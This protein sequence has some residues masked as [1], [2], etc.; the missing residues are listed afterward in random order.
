MNIQRMNRIAVRSLGAC[1]MLVVALATQAGPDPLQ[2]YAAQLVSAQEVPS[3]SSVARGSFRATVDEAGQTIE[4]ELTF[5]DLEAAVSQAHIHTAQHGVNGGIMLWLCGTPALPGPVGTPA[6]PAS[7]TITGTLTP[8]QIVA[9]PAQ[10][11]APGEFAEV[12]AAL[13]NGV[14]YANVHS[15]KFPGGEIR[16]QISRVTRSIRGVVR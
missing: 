4:Y 15:A 5:T 1:S 14:A 6:C 3:V 10:G 12:V 13:R 8:T 11:I 7:G 2:R 16:G 9:V